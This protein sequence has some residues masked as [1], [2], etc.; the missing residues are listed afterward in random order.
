MGSI[1]DTL[2]SEY[3]INCFEENHLAAPYKNGTSYFQTVNTFKKNF[4]Q[5]EL[6]IRDK[7]FENWNG[8]NFLMRNT[9]TVQLDNIPVVCAGYGIENNVQ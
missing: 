6:I 4:L 7:K 3:V 8:W 9:E 1:G 2:A 5:S